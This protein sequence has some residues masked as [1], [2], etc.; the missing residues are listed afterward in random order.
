M[1]NTKLERQLHT[2]LRTLSY[3]RGNGVV[4]ADDAQR[5]LGRK[6]VSRSMRV[7]L[8]YINRTFSSSTFVNVGQKPSVRE[9]AKGRKITQWFAVV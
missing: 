2:Y 8:A 6:K 4:T 1:E 7:R 5:F 9:E 3:N